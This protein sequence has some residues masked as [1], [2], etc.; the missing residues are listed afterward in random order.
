MMPRRAHT[1]IAYA[2]VATLGAASSAAAD[3][4]TKVTVEP[5]VVRP[6]APVLVTVTGSDAMPKGK[7]NGAALEF[8]PARKGYQAVFAIPLD[9]KAETISIEVNSAVQPASVQVLAATF[10]EA[11]LVVED[12]MA[13][14]GKE[15]R[16]QID[17]DNAAILRA[18]AKAKGEPQFIRAFKKPPGAVTSSFGE[19]RTFNDGHRSQHLGLD[20]AARPNTK[21]KAVNAGTVVLVRDCFLAGKVV[22]IAHGAGIA[23]AYY[24][25][26]ETSVAEG[27][28]VAQGADLGLAGKT[29]R[30]TGPHLHISVRVPG[31]LVDPAGF[32]KLSLAPAPAKVTQN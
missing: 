26:S 8:F 5:K 32:F 31:G 20:L 29:G 3:S 10:P 23:T 12:E 14:P 22:V 13:N 4:N 6:G 16:A 19:W 17:A 7:A 25:L 30:A 15:E 11:K 18:V 21:V 9:A 27:A 24:H 2:F 28:T 1:S